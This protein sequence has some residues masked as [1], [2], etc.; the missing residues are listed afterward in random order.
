MAKR[1]GDISVFSA[2]FLDVLCCALGGVILLTIALSTKVENEAQKSEG[3][4][5]PV[6]LAVRMDWDTPKADIDLAVRGPDGNI[7]SYLDRQ[8]SW[9]VLLRDETEAQT[10]RWEFFCSTDLVPGEYWV[11]C[12]YFDGSGESFPVRGS[13]A[14]YPGKDQQRKHDFSTVLTRFDRMTV[15]DRKVK[16]NGSRKRVASFTLRDTGGGLF[17]IAFGQ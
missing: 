17:D 16:T 12:S 4:E 1:S 6:L 3:F 8:R 11:Y 15:E 2:S 13:I 14:L 5:I 7:V 10:T 9:G